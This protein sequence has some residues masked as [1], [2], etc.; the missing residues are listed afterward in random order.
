VVALKISAP[1][2][3]LAVNARERSGFK[4]PQVSDLDPPVFWLP[5]LR[6]Q[7]RGRSIYHETFCRTTNSAGSRR[8][9]QN[10]T[11]SCLFCQI[12]SESFAD[13][14]LLALRGRCFTAGALQVFPHVTCYFLRFPR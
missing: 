5:T 13:W 4:K 10:S 8:I 6:E 7:A 2:G 14:R 9:A 12:A 3:P 1:V 11:D